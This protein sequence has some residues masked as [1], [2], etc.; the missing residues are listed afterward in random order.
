MNPDA[1]AAIYASDIVSGFDIYKPEKMNVLFSRYGD[2][3]A[4]FFQLLRSMGFEKS[5]ALDV[6]GHYEENHIHEIIHS[7]EAVVSPATGDPIEFTL[8]VN[9][10]DVNNNFYVR[11]WDEILF[12][13]EVTGSVVDIDVS[14]PGAPV[15]TV[16]PSDSTD[17]IPALAAGQEIIIFTSAFSEGS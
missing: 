9:D 11:L 14:A 10:L 8:D 17:R 12:N 2:Q 16:E 1:I 6:Y 13:N 3:G 7:R 4:S 5:V 15:I